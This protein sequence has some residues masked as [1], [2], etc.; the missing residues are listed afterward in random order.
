MIAHNLFGFDMFFSIKGYRATAWGTKYLNFGGTNL[1]DISY[2]N[3]AGEIKFIDTLKYYQKSLGELAAMLSEDEKN[4]VKHLTKQFFNQH[5]YFSEV[6]KY[7]G[8]SQ[9]NKIIEIIAEGKGIIP[10]EKIVD[11]NSMFLTPENDAFFEKSK[12]YIDLK[13]NAVSDSD[14]ESSFFLYKTLKMQNF[15]GMNDLHSAQDVILLC[16]IA[17]NRFQ[18]MHDQYG[19]NPRKCN[20]ASTLSD[21]IER[22]MSRVI[23]ALP[24]SIEAVYIFNKQ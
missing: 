10:Y 11:I 15:G 5:S 7:L 1:T 13:Q 17:E 2:G 24:T 3:I 9:K 14:Y 21:C 22:E 23:I 16:E 6:W 8:Y 19:F 4:S 20:S 18:F 12:F